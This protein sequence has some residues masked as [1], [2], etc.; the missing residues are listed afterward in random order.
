MPCRR[1]EAGAADKRLRARAPLVSS[2]GPYAGA[3]RS[4]SRSTL[5]VPSL[6]IASVHAKQQRAPASERPCPPR[7]EIRC[8][9][10]AGMFGT[11]PVVDSLLLRHSYTHAGSG[12]HDLA[13]GAYVHHCAGCIQFSHAAGLVERRARDTDADV[14]MPGVGDAEEGD[15]S[16]PG[17]PDHF[18]GPG[19]HACMIADP[20]Q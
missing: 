18:S 20:A 16:R 7:E 2:R 1:A 10:H 14:M 19:M 11:V 17:P 5:F 12:L 3:G 15:R 9:L 4:L 8:T 6:P 13:S